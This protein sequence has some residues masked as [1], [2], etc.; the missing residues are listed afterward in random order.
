MKTTAINNDVVF[1]HI[2][3]CG[4]LREILSKFWFK[5]WSQEGKFLVK[6]WS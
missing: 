2:E 5:M 4:N 6:M 3:L 1:F